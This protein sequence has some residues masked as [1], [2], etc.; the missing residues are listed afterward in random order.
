MFY[1]F[2]KR[3]QLVEINMMSYFDLPKQADHLPVVL[4]YDEVTRL[5]DSIE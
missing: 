5:L 3:E 1:K 2:L 4:S